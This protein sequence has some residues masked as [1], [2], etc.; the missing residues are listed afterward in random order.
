MNSADITDYVVSIQNQYS[1]MLATQIREVA[2]LTTKNQQLNKELATVKQ[3]L[4]QLQSDN[5]NDNENKENN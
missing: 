2:K 3:Q 5:S 4:A 1:I